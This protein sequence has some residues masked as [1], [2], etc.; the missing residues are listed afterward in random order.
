MKNKGI[1]KIKSFDAEYLSPDSSGYPTARVGAHGFWRWRVL[2][3]GVV[4]DSRK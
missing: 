1:S 2:E 4:A 3:R